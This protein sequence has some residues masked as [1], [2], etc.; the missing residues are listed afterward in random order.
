VQVGIR[1]PKPLV[2]QIHI[3]ATSS[4]RNISA[5]VEILVEA[6]LQA[7]KGRE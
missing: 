6:G 1:L 3:G 2:E 4:K 5:Q 7:L